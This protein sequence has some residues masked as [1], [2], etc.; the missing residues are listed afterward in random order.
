MINLLAFN[1]MPLIISKLM[2][3][4]RNWEI[5]NASRVIIGKAIRNVKN[6]IRL[7]KHAHLDKIVIV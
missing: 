4:I 3:I 6:V 1:V 5:V 2:M 7:A